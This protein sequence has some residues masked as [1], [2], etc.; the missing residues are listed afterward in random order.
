M[1]RGSWLVARG[2]WLVARN[3]QNIIVKHSDKEIFFFHFFLKPIT[4]SFER[5]PLMFDQ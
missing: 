4:L 5:T 3:R 1:T 2:S